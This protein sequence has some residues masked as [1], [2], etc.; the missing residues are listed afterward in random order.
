MI[1]PFVAGGAAVLVFLILT[2]RSR[3]DVEAELSA[4]LLSAGLIGLVSGMLIGL[5]IGTGY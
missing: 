4:A 1:A 3:A 2:E 5:L